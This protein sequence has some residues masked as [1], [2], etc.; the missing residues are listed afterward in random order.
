MQVQTCFTLLQSRRE[1]SS[2][3]L[4]DQAA[5]Q[6]NASSGQHGRESPLADGGKTSA[7]QQAAS[8]APEAAQHSSSSQ[9]G[10]PQEGLA[11]RNAASTSQSGAP[12]AD[13][14][15]AGSPQQAAEPAQDSSGPPALKDSHEEEQQP[16]PLTPEEAAEKATA[17]SMRT[18]R[19][20]TLAEQADIRQTPVHRMA[21][22]HAGVPV[23]ARGLVVW[24]SAEWVWLPSCSACVMLK[25]HGDSEADHTCGAGRHQATQGCC[26]H[27][28]G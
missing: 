25:Q 7:H 28:Q 27:T 8:D 12:G 21:V 3:P 15:A 13:G 19:L 5:E 11:P 4:K 20:A 22:H 18:A 10:D 26:G 14:S 9:Q 6:V 2:A 17:E 1:S 16:A 24:L 23:L